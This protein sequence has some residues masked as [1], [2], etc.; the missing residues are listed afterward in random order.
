MNPLFKKYQTNQDEI[1]SNNPYI[2]NTTVYTPQSRKSFYKFISNTYSDFKLM[3]KVKGDIDEDACLTDT[4][5]EE[6]MP[7]DTDG[8]GICDQMESEDNSGLPGFGL[9]SAISMLAIAAFARK[10]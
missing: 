9:I 10:E 2:T 4:L 6:D 5:D 7:I 8:D 1:Q 3:R